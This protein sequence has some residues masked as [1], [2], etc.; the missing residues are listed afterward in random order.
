MRKMVKKIV[1]SRKFNKYC[2]NVMHMYNVGRVN[3]P[4]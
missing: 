1:E 3:I 2:V 4:A